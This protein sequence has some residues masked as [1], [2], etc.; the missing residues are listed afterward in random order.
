MVVVSVSVLSVLLRLLEDVCRL[1]QGLHEHHGARG[2]I[3]RLITFIFAFLLLRIA[4]LAFLSAVLLPRRP[5]ATRLLGWLE[6]GLQGED[7]VD[8][9]GEREGTVR[10]TAS[11]TK[12]RV[13]AE[14]VERLY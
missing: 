4:L 3:Q 13:R 7:K 1:W 14:L 10:A 9:H 8:L 2:D 5:A 12:K 11:P 6:V